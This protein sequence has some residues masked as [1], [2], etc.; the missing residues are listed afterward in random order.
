MLSP[1]NDRT[2]VQRS[3]PISEQIR[4]ILRERICKGDYGPDGRIPSESSLATEFRAS[5]ATIRTA[6][7]GL[8]AEG[9]LFRKDGV[10][11]F[12][13]PDGHRLEAGLER[14]ESVLAMAAR[15]Q[16]KTQVANLSVEE[17]G[18]GEILLERLRVPENTP[19]TCVRR[20]VMVD[21]KPASYQVDFVLKEFL[22]PNDLNGAFS[23]SVLDLLQHN[24]DTLIGMAIAEVTAVSADRNLSELLGVKARSPLLLLRETLFQES[25][26]VVGCS[27]N[28]FVPGQFSFRVIRRKN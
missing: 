12:I 24:P 17:I 22:P 11:T 10:G 26:T 23:G 25:G 20:T 19:V 8:A 2:S 1:H 5:R 14:L 21:G 9:L 15:E 6:L 28:Y 18:A 3:K 13:R 7:A 16:M 27:D 4:D